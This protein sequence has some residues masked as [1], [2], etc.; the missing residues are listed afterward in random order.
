MSVGRGRQ[1]NSRTGT[2]LVLAGIVGVLGVTFIAGVW[3][4][5][6]WPVLTGTPRS[7]AAAEPAPGRKRPRSP[8]APVA[9]TRCR[10]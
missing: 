1:R 7:P 8:S 4:G 9:S 5:H 10:R 3:T 2:F 6:N